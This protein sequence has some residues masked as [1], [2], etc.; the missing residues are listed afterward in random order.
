MSPASRNSH[1]DPSPAPI[2][3]GRERE[4][5]ELRRG[6]SDAGNGAGRLFLIVGEAGIGKTRLVQ[7]LA[8]SGGAGAD[9]CWARCLEGGGAPAYWPWIQLLRAILHE[10]L[11]QEIRQA[12]GEGA[13]L[14]AALVPELRQRLPDVA[15]LSRPRAFE[16]EDARF[17][18]FDAVTT[19]L[20]NLA[21]TRPFVLLFDDLHNADLASL[22]LLQ[23]VARQLPTT[24]L[25]IVG[26]YRDADVQRDAD[27][28]PVLNAIARDGQR[29]PLSG[30]SEAEVGRFV[31]EAFALTPSPQLLANLHQTT[32]GNPFFVDE[33]ARLLAARQNTLPAGTGDTRLEIPHGVR[34]TI[35]Q[36]LLP[37]PAACHDVLA[38]AT[39][40]GREFDLLSLQEATERSATDLL[41]T[42]GEAHTAGVLLTIAGAPNRY[43]FTHALLWET[44]YDDM[45]PAQRID[46]HHRIALA[47]HRRHARNPLPHLALLAHHFYHGAAGGDATK[48]VDYCRQAGQHAVTVFAY[49][50]AAQHYERAEQVLAL[51]DGEHEVERLDLLLARGDAQA[52]ALSVDAARQTFQLVAASARHLRMPDCFAQAALGF[53]GLGLG[54][55][56]GS[57]DAAAVSLLE[58]ALAQLGDG[59]STLRARVLARLAV[60]LYFSDT[61]ERRFRLGNEA[62][63]M[64]ERVA[65]PITLAAV[66]SAS[67]FAQWGSIDAASQLAVAKRA[68]GL[69]EAAGDG[70]LLLQT[71]LWLLL[72]LIEVGDFGAWDR[73]IEIYARL[74]ESMR[75]PRYRGIANT[76]RGLRALTRGDFDVAEALAMQT[77]AL[78]ESSGDRTAFVSV[79]WQ[80]LVVRQAQG[81]IA[82]SE[83]LLRMAQSQMPGIGAFGCLLALLYGEVG[84]LDEARRELEMLAEDDFG[85]LA[86]A[87]AL[88]SLIPSLAEVCQALG[89]TR[90][91]AILYDR[92]LP[93]AASN[94]SHGPTVSFGPATHTL[95]IL[96]ATQSQWDVA[97]A[98][99][100][101]ALERSERMGCRPWV[102]AT[103]YQFARALLT[104]A[105]AGDQQHAQSLIDAATSA[106]A[107]MR[108]VSLQEKLKTLSSA[109]TES[110]PVAVAKKPASVERRCVFRR[111]GEYWAVGLE[112][113]AFRLKDSKGLQHIAQL[114]EHPQREYFVTDLVMTEMPPT[115]G[116]AAQLGRLTSEQLSRLGMRRTSG[117]AADA[118]IDA[119]AR[120][121]YKRHLDLLRQQLSEATEFNEVDRAARLQGE[122]DL[123]ADELLSGGSRASQRSLR[124]AHV[125]RA[126][127]NVTRTIKAALGRIGARDPDLGR[128]LSNTI[129][130]GAFCS[131][132]PD[133]LAAIAWMF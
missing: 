69:A 55:P 91:A 120:S 25:A 70:E 57:V 87:N 82:E 15:G 36:R 21:A 53:V 79:G 88:A 64:A 27:L 46:W 52:R 92:L 9:V 84:R 33:V 125:E 13:A 18:L 128:Y 31:H 109:A 117:A 104:R 90:R 2:F 124:A 8:S 6:V 16:T 35:R 93:R 61:A 3:I 81:R 89:D 59:D 94:I 66:V 34:A 123:L 101:D 96:A 111:E 110:L 4:L 19:L 26:T 115:S 56:R 133:P 30:W 74:A 32:E 76:L 102:A 100:Q 14:V 43:S 119:Q 10:R 80:V 86:R 5:L 45:M 7:E 113:A 122:I 60:E 1:V 105:A 73:D 42:L 54:V 68:V 47:L 49:E 44:L 106:A 41:G 67:H 112:T 129:K 85:T 127:L 24:H 38:V 118:P 77:I 58:E 12:L 116:A 62:V 20:R 98:H 95:G 121:D 11:P 37:L 51:S 78:G 130:T 28:A 107:A 103:Q 108:W 132:T 72:D 48:A 131:Y 114:L 23:F 17:P 99:F 29:L 40:L 39:V 75:L 50:E 65:D 22:L 71:R 126:R 83:P 63:A 97:A